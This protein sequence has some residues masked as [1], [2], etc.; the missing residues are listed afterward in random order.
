[1]VV[2]QL[3]VPFQKALSRAVI[4]MGQ[5]FPVQDY[6]A[7]SACKPG[8]DPADQPFNALSIQNPRERDPDSP[9]PVS[10]FDFQSAARGLLPDE[11]P[12]LTPL[13]GHT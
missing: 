3:A 4:Q 5:P 7:A 2:A 10:D 8:R 11:L 6:P 13:L 12:G 1:M 9:F